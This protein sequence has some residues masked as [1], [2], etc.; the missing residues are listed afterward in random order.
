MSTQPGVTISPSASISRRPGPIGSIGSRHGDDL[1]T[2]DRHIGAET[3]GAG[4]VDHHATSNHQIVHVRTVVPWSA[5]VRT[6]EPDADP[7]SR[8][9]RLRSGLRQCLTAPPS[10]PH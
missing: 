5:H 9:R 4:A 8:R 7:W 10:V 3:I 6:R 1:L 2:V